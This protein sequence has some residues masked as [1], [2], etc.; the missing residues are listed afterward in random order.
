MVPIHV[1]VRELQE[2]KPVAM[3]WME[4]EI[5]RILTKYRLSVGQGVMISNEPAFENIPEEDNT[6]TVWHSLTYVECRY[7]K[8]DV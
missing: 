7:V 6:S 8:K 2:N 3:T 4:D 5:V 1:F